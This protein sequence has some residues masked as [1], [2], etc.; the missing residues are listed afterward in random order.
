MGILTVLKTK[1]RKKVSISNH[2]IMVPDFQDK[3][4][5]GSTILLKRLNQAVTE[6]GKNKS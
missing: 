2:I 3:L 6:S 1:R 4:L 5:P